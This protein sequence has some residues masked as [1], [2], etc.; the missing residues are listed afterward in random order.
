ADSMAGG[1]GN[2][3]YAV[4][5]AGDVVTEN[6]G[7]GTDLVLSSVSFTLSNYVENLTLTGSST[8]TGTGNG[9]DNIITSNNVVNTLIGG[10][11]N[12]TYI[13]SNSSDVVSENGGEGTDLVQSSVTFTLAANVENLTL[14][15]S[16]NIDGTGN[17]GDNTIT[18]NSGVN[19]LSGSDGNDFL[20]GMGGN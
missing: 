18:G 2:D 7:E 15:G 9:L 5:N 17:T 10:A 12:D 13:V 4:D 6:S 19:T 11:G 1:A 8:I 3:T 16:S 14:T 20:Y